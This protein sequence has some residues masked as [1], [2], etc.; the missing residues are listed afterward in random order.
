M[1]RVPH[2]S[3]HEL[4]TLQPTRP[5]PEEHHKWVPYT[6]DGLE[7]N[8]NLTQISNSRTIHLAM[9]SLFEIQHESLY[10][11]HVPARLL[12]SQDVLK[13]YTRYLAWLDSLVDTIRLGGNST[14][15]VIFMQL[16]PHRHIS[17]LTIHAGVN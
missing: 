14:P 17:A 10:A 8:G 13:I 7:V 9:C 4:P 3:F 5:E 12:R 16:V 6:G 1:R 2:L 15:A 11:L